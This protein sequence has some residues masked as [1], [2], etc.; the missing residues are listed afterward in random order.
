MRRSFRNVAILVSALGI[1]SFVSLASA[2]PKTEAEAKKL[3]SAAMDE[4]FLMLELKGAQKKLDEA[5]KKCGGGKC[6]EAIVA[7]LQRDL[8]IVLIN[9]KKT[10][11]GQKAFEAAFAADASVTI[12][13]DYL[14]NADV[15]KAWEAAKKTAGAS[16][17]APTPSPT[18]TVTA[19]A[20]APKPPAGGSAEGNLEVKAKLAPVSY[21]LPVIIDLPEGLDVDTIKLSYKTAAMEK[22]KTLDA[23]KDSGKYVVTIGCED[24]QFVGEIKYYVR[25]YDADKNEVEHLGTLKKPAVIKLVDKMPDDVE[26]PSYPGDREPEKCVEKGDCQ[27]GFPCDKSASKKPQGSGCESDDE[28]DAGLSCVENE[29]GKKWCYEAGAPGGTKTPSGGGKKLWLGLDIQQDFLFISGSENICKESTWACTKQVEGKQTDIGVS[30]DKGIQ[31]AEGGGGKTSGG[32]ALATTRV[33]IGGDYFVT[34]SITVG[35]RVGYAFRGG[36]PTENAKFLP[37]H[38]EARLQY[39]FGQPKTSGARPFAMLSGGLAEFDALVPNIVAVPNSGARADDPAAC[40]AATTPEEQ[41]RACRI[42]GIDAYRLAGQSFI[43]PGGGVW[44]HLGPSFAL[45]VAGKILLPLPT[46]S[47]GL[48]L[49][50][51]GKFGL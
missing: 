43:A 46:F 31:V 24:T 25:A 36:N 22:F 9:A 42:T 40:A 8:G 5:I 38:A 2:D 33:F 19:T 12:G 15:A 32:P 4:D 6:S 23:K 29:N 35:A 30:D 49:E 47:P 34:P 17:P 39:F 26:A 37:F 18:P 11:E 21:P 3:Q 28:C 16:A 41:G 45:N 14:A 48:A 44:I 51:G 27:P 7:G 20:T 50:V 10:K 13:K 1:G